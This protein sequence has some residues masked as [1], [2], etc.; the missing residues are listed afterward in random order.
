MMVD[1]GETPASSL[2]SM[3]DWNNSAEIE[4]YATKQEKMLREDKLQRVSDYF[5]QLEVKELDENR[6]IDDRIR[7][8]FEEG[9][10]TNPMKSTKDDKESN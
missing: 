3:L 1:E 8:L 9:L 4:K 2:C 10:D 6:I 5:G 7:C